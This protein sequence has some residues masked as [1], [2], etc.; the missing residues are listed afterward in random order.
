MDGTI[1]CETDPV[2]Y[3]YMMLFDRIFEE[4]KKNGGKEELIKEINEALKTGYISHE[5]E[6]LLSD[7][8]YEYYLNM[9][10]E[11]YKKGLVF[12][13]FLYGDGDRKRTV[14]AGAVVHIRA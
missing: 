10:I 13:Q 2:Y 6:L 1:F 11:E 5:F 8:E 3:E 4:N 9:T 12:W 14:G 7:S